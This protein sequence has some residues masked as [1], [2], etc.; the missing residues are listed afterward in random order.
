MLGSWHWLRGWWLHKQAHNFDVVAP[1][2]LLAAV[3][4]GL[5]ARDPGRAGRTRPMLAVVVPAL[6]TL[7]IWFF[8]APDPRF[9]YAPMWLP[10][11]DLS[12][13]PSRP[14]DARHAGSRWRSL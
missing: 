5:G 4:A 2:L 10:R 9:V 6:A 3:L 12:P 1:L 7:A 11:P 13:G 14:W 8:V